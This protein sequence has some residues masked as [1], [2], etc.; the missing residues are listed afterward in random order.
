MLKLSGWPRLTWGRTVMMCEWG[1]PPG[2]RRSDRVTRLT[3]FLSSTTADRVVR[4]KGL[5]FEPTV[6]VARE[7]QS[8]LP[9]SGGLWCVTR[10]PGRRALDQKWTRAQLAFK[11]SMVHGILQFTPSI[12]FRY[13]LHRCESRDIR[14]RESLSLLGSAASPCGP[15]APAIRLP[16]CLD[17]LGACRA[18]GL[19]LGDGGADRPSRAARSLSM[20]RGSFCRYRQ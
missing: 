9:A 7:G 15:A 20:V 17:F 12:A 2:S 5:L 6:L 19:L 10:R 18:G 14:C 16:S 8:P 13:V 3:R 4:A 1:A 11:D